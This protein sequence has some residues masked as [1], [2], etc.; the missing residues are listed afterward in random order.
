METAHAISNL[1]EQ[2]GLRDIFQQI[3]GDQNLQ[4]AHDGPVDVADKGL[5]SLMRRLSRFATDTI[6]TSRDV[7]LDQVDDLLVALKGVANGPQTVAA[8]FGDLDGETAGATILT[9][10]EAAKSA[11]FQLGIDTAVCSAVIGRTG[12]T[13]DEGSEAFSSCAN[14]KKSRSL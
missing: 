4:E 7:A 12:M 10:E 11:Q 8:K 1:V 2:L 3:A 6:G 5:G 14:V 13:L 9:S